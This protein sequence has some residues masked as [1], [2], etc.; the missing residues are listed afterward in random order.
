MSAYAT[1]TLADTPARGHLRQREEH[2]GILQRGE[3]G[4]VQIPNG[5]QPWR[6]GKQQFTRLPLFGNIFTTQPKLRGVFPNVQ[7]ANPARTPEDV[8][9]M[10]IYDI[11]WG[12]DEDATS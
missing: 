10:E 1:G 8:A 9:I 4:E 12:N 3:V 11:C 5:G 6:N 7:N 2:R